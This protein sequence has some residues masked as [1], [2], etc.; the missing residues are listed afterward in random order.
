MAYIAKKCIGCHSNKRQFDVSYWLCKVN[1]GKYYKDNKDNKY[2]KLFRE[3]FCPCV[4]C[5]VKAICT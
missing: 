1:I 3:Q 2:Y 5:L 4:E